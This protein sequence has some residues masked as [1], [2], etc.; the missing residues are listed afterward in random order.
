MQIMQTL[1]LTYLLCMGNGEHK[2]STSEGTTKQ[3]ILRSY[4]FF[5]VLKRP[6]L[7]RLLVVYSQD[8]K[9]PL[10]CSP[11]RMLSMNLA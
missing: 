6:G 3:A 2:Y 10:K 5:R 11:S 8:E 9:F 4:D 1:Q 7:R